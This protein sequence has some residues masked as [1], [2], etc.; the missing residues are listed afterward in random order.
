MQHYSLGLAGAII[1][2]IFGLMAI[3]V[4]STLWKLTHS[5]DSRNWQLAVRQLICDFCWILIKT[6]VRREL[7]RQSGKKGSQ[8][9]RWCDSAF[10]IAIPTAAPGML[11]FF[12]PHC[13]SLFRAPRDPGHTVYVF[14]Y[15]ESVTDQA[16]ATRR[17][18]VSRFMARQM[19]SN[20]VS[21]YRRGG[22]WNWKLN[23]LSR[24]QSW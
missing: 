5:F 22:S 17:T 3:G 4:A 20:F 13:C 10:K 23:L 21:R 24:I 6:L 19:G 18:R 11:Q 7:D 1:W 8:L 16:N 12:M 15:L 9:S 14:L 2:L